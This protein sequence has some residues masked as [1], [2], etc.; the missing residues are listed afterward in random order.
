MDCG[1]DITL[2]VCGLVLPLRSEAQLHKKYGLFLGVVQQ[3]LY[4][5]YL[6][7][8]WLVLT[9]YFHQILQPEQPSNMSVISLKYLFIM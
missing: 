3:S 4:R 1:C 5:R 9:V 6:C 8:G 2:Q 7:G